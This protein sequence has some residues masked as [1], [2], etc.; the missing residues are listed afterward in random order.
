MRCETFSVPVKPP[1]TNRQVDDSILLGFDAREMPSGNSWDAARRATYLLRSDART[2][3]SVD[4]RVWPSVVAQGFPQTEWRG[5]NPGLWD[6][7]ARMQASVGPLAAAAW[8]IAV[9]CIADGSSEPPE[10]S[11]LYRVSTA[12]PSLDS[13]WQLLGFDVADAAF[14][15]GL[16]NCGYGASEVAALRASWAP[17]LNARHLFTDAPT[18][19]AFK[20][21]SDRRVPEHAPFFVYALHRRP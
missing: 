14:T 21:L 6:E 19:L 7:L 15:S 8:I 9:S 13:E 2:P 11:G 10:G 16:S 12:P 4:A 5:A 3:L 1:M 18:A 17:M 20:E